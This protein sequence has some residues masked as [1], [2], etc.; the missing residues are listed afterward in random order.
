MRR[1]PD[2]VPR[3]TF[4]NEMAAERWRYRCLL[5]G[6]NPAEAEASERQAKLA[7]IIARH[8]I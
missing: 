3:S 7:E 6:R 5:N 2:D 8:A 4:G 1:L